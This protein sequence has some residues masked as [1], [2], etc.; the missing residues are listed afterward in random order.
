MIVIKRIVQ[1]SI[2]KKALMSITGLLLVG[3]LVAHLAGNINMFFGPD[4]MNNYGKSLRNFPMLLWVARGG[5]IVIFLIHFA[6]AILLTIENRKARPVRYAYNATMQT[7]LASRTMILTGLVLLSFVIYHLMHYTLGTVHSEFFKKPDSIDPSR[8]DIYSMVILSFRQPL[9]TITYLIS[10]F[11]LAVHLSH[12]I[13][14]SF[15]SL[16][17]NGERY[18]STL[19]TISYTFATLL[20]LGFASIPVSILTGFVK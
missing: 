15:Q 2:G 18:Q 17:F 4:A 12:G 11:I 3:F 5:L 8:E 20:F 1:S 19:K 6:M 10:L 7:S 13:R 16:G 9:I 14:S